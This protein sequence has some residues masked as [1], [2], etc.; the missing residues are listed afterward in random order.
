VKTR[1]TDRERAA[2]PGR[3][4]NRSGVEPAR[5]T[6][7]RWRFRCSERQRARLVSARNRGML[8]RWLRRTTKTAV[9]RDPLRR[10][11]DVLLHYRAAAVRTDLLEIAAM[12][13]CAHDP[14]PACVATLHN[15]LANADSPLYNPD[16]PF[17]KLEATLDQLRSCL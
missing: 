13:E 8:A 2:Q 11:R 9:D 17:S 16:I 6:L 5:G 10:R 15:L 12:L 14:D 7:E 3:A 4:P 1:Y